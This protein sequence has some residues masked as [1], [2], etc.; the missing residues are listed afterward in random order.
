MATQPQARSM[1]LQHGRAQE[2]APSVEVLHRGCRRCMGGPGSRPGRRLIV[3][4]A[5]LG[6]LAGQSGPTAELRG[7]WSPV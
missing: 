1:R 5:A 2:L 4:L 7:L 3:E 6:R